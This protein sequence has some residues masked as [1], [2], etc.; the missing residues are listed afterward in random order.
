[1][2][3]QPAMRSNLQSCDTLRL[4]T[5]PRGRCLPFWEGSPLTLR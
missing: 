1:M 5:T 2:M 4:C 3:P